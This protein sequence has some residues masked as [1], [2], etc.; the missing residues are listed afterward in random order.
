M[1]HLVAMTKNE[2]ALYKP[3]W[4]YLKNENKVQNS[5]Y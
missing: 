5:L 4:N 2:E 3:I 1:R